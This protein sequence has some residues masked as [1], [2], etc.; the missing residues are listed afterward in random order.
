VIPHEI[1]PKQLRAL[2]LL[3]VLVPLIPTALMIRFMR[4]ALRSERA[5]AFDRTAALYRQALLTAGTSFEKHLAT[6]S[7]K[8]SPQEAHN[9]FRGLLD[10]AVAIRIVGASGQPLTALTIPAQQPIAQ[11]SLGEYRL[12]WSVQLHLLDRSPLDADASEQARRYAWIVGG[13]LAVTVAFAVAAGITVSRQL[14]LQELKSTAV[15][16]VAH[17]L[18]TPLA[19]MRMLVDTLRAGRYRNEE[20]LQE[21]LELV[22][23]ENERLSRLTENF[24]T[25]AR[26]ERGSA[27][28]ELVP[29]EIRSVIDAALLPFRPRLVAPRCHFTL[30]IADPLPRVLADRDALIT[31]LSNLLDNALK[32]TGDEKRISLRASA[33]AD[34]ATLSLS[35]NGLGLSVDE[36]KAIFAPFFQVDRKLSRTTSGCGLGLSIVRQLVAALHGEIAVESEPGRGSTFL[37]RLPLA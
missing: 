15:A 16:T 5:A 25:L 2:L 26:L 27:Q 22:G 30:E 24:L 28:L 18:R 20:Q 31:I 37:V 13:T 14:R 23:G 17:E 12:P 36:R 35:D 11:L 34:R 3:L 7:A 19:S 32:Y 29:V 9:F 33:E 6:R 21:Y 1:R 4:D 10:R 8:I